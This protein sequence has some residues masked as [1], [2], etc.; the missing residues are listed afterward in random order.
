[1]AYSF[2]EKKRI[3][4]NFGKQGSILE[5]PYLLAIQLDSY[6]TFLQ[7]NKAEEKREDIGLHAAFKTVFPIS[8]YSGNAI[9]EY[10]SYRL[11]EPVFDVK[12]CQ[13]RGLTYAAPL[14]VKVRLI[15]LD[16]EAA[17]A[18]KPIKDV[19]EQE[20]Y[21][22][23]LPLMTDNGTFV[24]N[25]TER[26]IVSQ[27][28][29]SP[30]VFFDHD[31]GKSHSSGKLLFSARII[32][33]RGS[34]LDFEFDPKD[35][36]FARIDRRRKLPVSIILRALGMN[37]SEILDM[38]FDKNHFFI[39][40]DEVSLEL[41]PA[42]LRGET[43]TFEIRIGDQVIVE[44]GRRITARHVRQLEDAG[45]KKLTVPREY[46]YGKILS[47]DVVNTDTGEVLAKANEVLT[48]A[49]V[50][51]LIEAGITEVMTLYTNDLDRG[52]YISDTLRIDP[53]KTRLEALVEIY[54]MMRP[55][56]PPTKDAAENLFNNLF[57]NQER[58]DLS[59]VGRMKFNR[60]V[61]RSEIT[62][63]SV[64]SKED[65]LDVLKVLISIR[66]GE[67]GVDDIDH[68]GNRRVRS[69]G[70]MAENAFRV[71]L[72]RVERAVKE[73]LTIAETEPLMP[74]EMINAKPVAAAVKEFFGSSQLSQF[75]DQNNPLSEV[76]HKRRVSALGPGGLTRE[77]AGFEVRDVHPTHYGRVCPIET[78]E[79]PNIGLINSLSVYA[80]TNQYGFLETPY[81]RVENGHVTDKIEYL[82]AI[83]EGKYAIAQANSAMDAKG[84]L[85]DELV[86]LPLRERIHAH[87][88][89]SHQLHGRVAE[90]DRVGRGLADPVP[91]ARRR[92]PRA[93]GLEHAAP[94]GADAACRY[95]AGGHGHGASGGHRLG[96]HG[97]REARRH[98]RLGRRLAHRDPRERQ[99]DERERS[100]ASTS[101]A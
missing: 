87:A 44:E 20:V 42:R 69:V 83:E 11:G 82:S 90:A 9:L 78:P 74:Q 84:N 48:A 63:S 6:S 77:R 37:E 94:G 8:S 85:T 99:R 27:L 95:A 64:L 5:T 23:E 100:R 55:G 22:G 61:G 89:R 25:G 60:R 32:P 66:N 86:S 88:A 13:L 65:V 97:R 2:T 18:K 58:Y 54:R 51:K 26:V 3:R 45:V 39:G 40:R 91:R 41:V 73:R 57:F 68:L 98:R 35:A 38:F 29:R 12:E 28:H 36:V 46:I 76:T 52:P 75:M 50:E 30:G 4:K 17:G 79:G 96:R 31:R 15:V 24:I 93:D 92:E 49:S 72:V 10:V 21:L 34:W 56:E 33:Y 14:R 19:R 59:A 80:R 101:T 43:A 53:A 71:G 7:A 16:K 62:G 70:E 47:H 67:G 1:M 81:R